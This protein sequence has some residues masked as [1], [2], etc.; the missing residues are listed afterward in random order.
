MP[1]VRA[2]G[3]WNRN[4]PEDEMNRELFE[5]C[6]DIIKTAWERDTFSYKGKYW[7]FPAEE[8]HPHDHPVY[9]KYG[10]GVD[11]NGAIR[12][13][14]IAPKPLQQP[15]PLYS[16]FTHSMRT[17]LYWARVGGKPVVLSD[18]YEFCE[19]LWSRYRDEAEAHGRTVAPGEEAAW[20]GYLILAET[21]AQ[22]EEWANDIY[23]FWD[24]WSMPFGQ[25]YPAM[26]IGDV[27]TVSRKIEEA[28]KRLPFNEAYFLFG[29]GVL[30]RDKCMRT[31]ELFAE[32]VMPRFR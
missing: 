29:Q 31:L 23:W 32:K 9:Y 8:Q 25:S 3:P 4:E 15:I 21:Q 2:T 11:A 22:A 17:A 6:V 14:G 26:L 16:G 1:G 19:T 27:D 18:N 24:S 28:T 30:E 10:Q 12:E 20:G 5:E 13:I 7:T